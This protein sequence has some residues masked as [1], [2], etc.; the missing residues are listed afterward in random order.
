MF[1]EIKE[2]Q[3]ERIQQIVDET[4]TK[5]EHDETYSF[6]VNHDFGDAEPCIEE[7][8]EPNEEEEDPEE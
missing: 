5:P 3:K 2:V 8:E 6:A 7:E 4:I 1:S